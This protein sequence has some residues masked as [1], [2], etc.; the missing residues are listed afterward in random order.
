M[1]KAGLYTS[2]V[3][4]AAGAIYHG[5]WLTTAIEIVVG[6]A[7]AMGT[8]HGCYRLELGRSPRARHSDSCC[9]SS[10]FTPDS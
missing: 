4:F 9:P 7:V 6:G 3:I 1:Q 5:V 10:P 2:G 8:M